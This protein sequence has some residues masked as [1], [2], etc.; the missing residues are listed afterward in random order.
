MGSVCSA[1]QVDANRTK[2]MFEIAKKP[3][4]RSKQSERAWS[5]QTNACGTTFSHA[6]CR[7]E[8]TC[9]PISNRSEWVVQNAL[10]CRKQSRTLF[11]ERMFHFVSCLE[12]VVIPFASTWGSL[13][14]IFLDDAAT[15]RVM[16][17][18]LGISQGPSIDVFLSYARSKDSFTCLMLDLH[19]SRSLYTVKLSLHSRYPSHRNKPSASPILQPRAC[20]NWHNK[21]GNCWWP[22]C[23]WENLKKVSSISTRV[24]LM[25]LIVSLWFT[26]EMARRD[27]PLST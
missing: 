8:R 2:N 19:I 22:N 10:V 9:V 13:A 15:A 7:F 11:F 16:P 1:T 23:S 24:E 12:R 25:I 26:L 18:L 14:R 27:T 4:I 21:P 5:K 20:N 6:S 3:N 17:R